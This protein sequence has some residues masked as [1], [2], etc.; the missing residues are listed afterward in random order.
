MIIAFEG[1]KGAGMTLS[2]AY[3]AYREFLLGKKVITACKLIDGKYKVL[4][5]EEFL[6]EKEK[7][8]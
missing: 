7:E 4:D 8:E 1:V 5:K 2:G 3:I 6:E